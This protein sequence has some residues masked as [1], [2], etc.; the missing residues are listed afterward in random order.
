M[1]NNLD[2]PTLEQHVKIGQA[3]KDYRAAL[4]KFMNLTCLAGHAPGKFLYAKE[5]NKLCHLFNLGA[6]EQ[7][8]SRLEDVM[9]EDYPWLSNDAFG[10]YY[11]DDEKM[12]LYKLYKAAGKKYEPETSE[13]PEIKSLDDYEPATVDD[14]LRCADDF[15]KWLDHFTDRVVD[16]C[17][18]TS[19]EGSWLD[20]LQH[21]HREIAEMMRDAV[22]HEL[23]QDKQGGTL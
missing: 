1:G 12:T 23:N 6:V 14:V 13:L 17:S 10:V 19:Q 11:H 5:Q 9:F 8:K 20:N 18:Y 16:E 22:L 4:T 7:I 15:D 3:V 21:T 2:R